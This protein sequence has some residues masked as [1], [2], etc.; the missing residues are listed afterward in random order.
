MHKYTDV[1]PPSIQDSEPPHW[2]DDEI[3]SSNETSDGETDMQQTAANYRRSLQRQ[4]NG[5]SST[6]SNKR[7]MFNTSGSIG[8][9]TPVK[10]IL[11]KTAERYSWLTGK[12]TLPHYEEGGVTQHCWVKGEASDFPVRIGPNYKKQ[13]KKAPSLPQMFECIG[14]A[15]YFTTSDYDEQGNRPIGLPPPIGLPKTCAMPQ[16]IIIHSRLAVN[17]PLEGGGTTPATL[18]LVTFHEIS[19]LT[20]EWCTA[21]GQDEGHSEDA[22]SISELKSAS[23]RDLSMSCRNARTPLRR[24]QSL[25]EQRKKKRGCCGGLFSR[26]K[27]DTPTIP[28]EHSSDYTT[29]PSEA[30]VQPP[31]PGDQSGRSIV[32]PQGND[33]FTPD[34]GGESSSSHNLFHKFSFKSKQQKTK[35]YKQSINVPPAFDVLL[36]FIHFP[37]TSEKTNDGQSGIPAKDKRSALKGICYCE[38]MEGGPKVPSL[39]SSFQKKPV[40]LTGQSCAKRHVEDSAYW[41]VVI[42]IDC[43]KWSWLARKG[44]SNFQ[45]QTQDFNLHASY[46]CQADDDQDLPERVMATFT[47]LK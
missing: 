21:V 4:S 38:Q 36:H 32:H 34:F 43:R 19:S 17:A 44:I 3:A 33:K 9:T 26:K 41:H 30:G 24:A 2:D 29:E 47:A 42:D 15:A 46:V 13:G 7:V 14:F 6:T 5:D 18:H 35:V 31:N 45:D 1:V 27:D 37:Y 28:S 10:S 22:P 8:N 25:R 23:Q 16:L 11:R 12:Y 39:I 20:R 40:M